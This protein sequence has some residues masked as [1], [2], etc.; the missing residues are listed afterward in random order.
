MESCAFGA[1]DGTVG[2]GRSSLPMASTAQG[3][4]GELFF[5]FCLELMKTER[6]LLDQRPRL[7]RR[8]STP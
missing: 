8:R 6:T 3:P 1:P 4:F 5:F 2:S 7:A